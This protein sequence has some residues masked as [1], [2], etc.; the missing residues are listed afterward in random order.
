M[1]ACTTLSACA[2]APP[3]ASAALDRDQGLLDASSQ[4]PSQWP[5]W[6]GN[7]TDTVLD[8]FGLKRPDVQDSARPDRHINWRIAASSSLNTTADGLPLSVL[9]RLYRLHGVDSFLQAP[10]GSF[11]DLD[12]E[13][14]AMGDELVSVKEVQIYPGKRYEASER[15]PREIK[16]IGV[17]MLYRN[18]APGR[19][20]YAFKA[21]TAEATGLSIG[22]HACAMSVQIGEPMNMPSG[23]ARHVAIPCP[24]RM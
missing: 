6:F 11:G 16:F 13:R 2:S 20:R 18:P 22:A 8:S 24:E 23:T 1:A 7:V 5:G 14:A 15:L 10:A 21:S 17:V 9:V 4:A 19:W 12:K 3:S